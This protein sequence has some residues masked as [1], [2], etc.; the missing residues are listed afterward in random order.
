M[1]GGEGDEDLGDDTVASESAQPGQVETPAADPVA[2][3]ARAEAAG[4]TS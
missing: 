1:G 2:P 3:E 4:G